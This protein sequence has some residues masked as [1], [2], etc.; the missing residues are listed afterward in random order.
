VSLEDISESY[1][2]ADA[3]KLITRITALKTKGFDKLD[4]AVEDAT[5]ELSDFGEGCRGIRRDIESGT[6]VLEDM[7]EA[8]SEQK[9]FE[10][11]IKTFLGVSGAA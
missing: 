10:D 8:A 11:K 5:E 1:S 3:N 9:A 2:E 4:T 7:T 6:E